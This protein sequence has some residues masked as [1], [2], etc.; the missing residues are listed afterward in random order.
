MILDMNPPRFVEAANTHLHP[1]TQHLLA[2]AE[3]A[4]TGGT[5]GSLR[6][7]GRAIPAGL[8]LEPCE[9]VGGKMNKR[10]RRRAGMLAAQFAVADHATERLGSCA[11]PDRSAKAAA[12]IALFV[13]HAHLLP[14]AP[15]HS[16][17][18]H[19]R[20]R[21]LP[22]TKIYCRGWTA[23]PLPS[24]LSLGSSL[25]P[26]LEARPSTHSVWFNPV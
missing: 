18:C 19:G 14:A 11:I 22:G 4:A 15:K 21:G 8:R 12:V 17:D 2:H 20:K 25:L 7:L 5:K 10:E 3:S 9:C 1:I 23:A 16:T 6:E 13:G 26:K 24:G